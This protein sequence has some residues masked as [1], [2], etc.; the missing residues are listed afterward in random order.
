MSGEVE[1]SN[2]H[3][4]KA[5]G[6]LFLKLLSIHKEAGPYEDVATLMTSQPPQA[7][8]NEED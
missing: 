3:S 1:D 8:A 5:N 6:Q 7:G 2:H 4:A